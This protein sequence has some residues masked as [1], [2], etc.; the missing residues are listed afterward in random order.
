[1]YVAVKAVKP[2]STKPI[3]CWPT[4]VVVTATCLP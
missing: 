2:L 1:M 4:G 3:S